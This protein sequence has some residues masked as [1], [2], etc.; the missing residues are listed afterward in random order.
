MPQSKSPS[1]VTIRLGSGMRWLLF[2][3]ALLAILGATFAVRWYVGNTVAEYSPDVTNG[4]IE[5]ARL[6]VRWAPGDPLT[7]WRLGTL[8]EKIFSADNIAA[9]VRQYQEAVAISPNDYRYWMELGRALEAAGDG[10]SGEKALRRAIDLAPAYSHPRW[11]LGNLLLREGKTEEAFDQLG[12]AAESDSQMRPQVFDLAMRVWDGDI[13]QIAKVT[14]ASP[15]GR[16][17]FAIYLVGAHRFDEAMRMWA[18]VSPAD[19]RAQAALTEDLKQSLVQAKQFRAALNVMREIQADANLPPAEQI[20]NGGF[21]SP[22]A[23]TTADIFG[24]VVNSRQLAQITLDSHGHTGQGSLR[25]IFRAPSSLDKIHVS[26]TMAVEPGTQYRLEYYVR[27]EGLVTAS[28]PV[29]TIVDALDG[30]VLATSKPL[31]SGTNDWQKVTV[32]FTTKPTHDG[33]TV[34]FSRARCSDTDICPIFGSVWYDDF[35]LQRS[36]A[37][38]SPRK[39]AGRIK[40]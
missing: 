6:A 3:P 9:A 25:I 28:T 21:E 35:N 31:P 26:Q 15:A 11:S 38:G 34:G 8:E 7:H 23:Q 20:W 40:R 13:E 12:R 1:V 16:L 27:T 37:A 29:L 30:N 33:M 5:M 4:G 24:W 2:L 39:D 32:D 19:R 10:A 36:G 18:A 22:L 17:Q 14:R